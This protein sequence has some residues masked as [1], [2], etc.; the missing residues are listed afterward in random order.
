MSTF[1]DI[2]PYGVIPGGLTVKHGVPCKNGERR[3]RVVDGPGKTIYNGPM[4]SVHERSGQK[5]TLRCEMKADLRPNRIGTVGDEFIVSIRFVTGSLEVYTGYRA[6]HKRR[7]EALQLADCSHGM[8][9][10]AVELPPDSGTGVGTDWTK[11]SLRCAANLYPID[12]R[13]SSCKMDGGLGS[14]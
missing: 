3:S 1:A 8:G 7:W 10:S 11:Y 5:A 4:W 14:F 13:K 12:S 2:D 9:H 6:M